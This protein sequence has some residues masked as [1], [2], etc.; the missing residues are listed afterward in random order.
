MKPRYLRQ[1]ASIVVLLATALLVSVS[2]AQ[3]S[4]GAGKPE[5]AIR[6]FY[7]WYVN[8]VSANRDP[9][10]DDSARLKRYATTRFMRE[11]E[12]AR[13]GEGIGADPFLQAQD[14]DKAWAKNIKVSEAKIS[15]DTATAKVELKGPEMGTHKLNVTMRNE[16]GAWKVDRVD[17]P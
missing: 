12:K 3:E 6:E 14:L 17:A 1:W 9:F 7:A 16:G 11:I 8:A 13:K 4:S 15:G 2:R 5:A 10:K